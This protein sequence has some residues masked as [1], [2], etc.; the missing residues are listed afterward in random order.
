MARIHPSETASSFIIEGI[1][2]TISKDSNNKD[3]IL[4]SC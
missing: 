3:S 4:E 1:M 2:D